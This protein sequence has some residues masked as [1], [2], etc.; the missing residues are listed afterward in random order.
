MKHHAES[1]EAMTLPEVHPPAVERLFRYVIDR[2]LLLPLGALIALVWA[3]TAAESYFRFS[4]TLAFAVNEVAMAFFFGLVAQEVWE[5]TMRGGALH[6]WRGWGLP[7][8]GAA[9]GVA[10]AGAVYLAYI[11]V[12]QEALLEQGWPIACAIDIAAAYYVLKI[13]WHRSRALPFVLLLALATDALGILVVALR[14]HTLPVRPGGVALA[15][16]AIAVAVTLKK[17]R[18]R[19]FW[20]YLLVCG[21]LFWFALYFEGVHPALALIPLVPFLPHRAR[22]IEMMADPPDDDDVHHF[23]H[24]WNEVVQVVL[25]LFGLINAGVLLRGYSTGTW[26]VMA[27]ALVGRPIG[28]LA[29]VALAVAFGFPLPRRVGWRGLLVI[30]LAT[31]SGFTFALFFATGAIP[32]GPVLA[33][34]KL[35]ALASVVAAPLTVAVARVLHVGRYARSTHHG[36]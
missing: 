2:F 18:V 4:H 6:T 3:N 35:G 22:R 8:I 27:A 33:Q 21:P 10:G 34:I 28:I 13:V 23:E 16:L 15:L 25:F 11:T 32:I 17:W 5:A 20:P 24:E 12:K 29:A 9:G 30:A 36:V 1:F 7:L 31:S 14:P 26:A 19:S